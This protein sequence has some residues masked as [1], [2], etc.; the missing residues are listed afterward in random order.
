VDTA[1]AHNGGGRGLSHRLAQ[2]GDRY[3]EGLRRARAGWPPFTEAEWSLLRDAMNG[4]VHEPAAMIAHIDQGIEDAIALD[5]LDAK[6]GVDG[7]ALLAKLRA[8]DFMQEV[9]LVEQIESWWAERSPGHGS[10]P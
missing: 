1:L 5:K 8:L 3:L 7:P 2:V 10:A 9:A 4:T 6:W